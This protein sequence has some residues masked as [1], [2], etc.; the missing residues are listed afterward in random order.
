VQNIIIGVMFAFQV[1]LAAWMVN[2]YKSAK[3]DL[4]ATT[5]E[6]PMLKEVSAL[7][8]SVKELLS[9]IEEA[10]QETTARLEVRCA[11]ARFVLATLE[12]RL[13]KLEMEEAT[14]TAP[15]VQNYLPKPAA[16]EM[17]YQVVSNVPSPATFENNEHYRKH[18]V[19]YGLADSGLNPTEISRQTGIAEGEVQL[20]L[21]LRNHHAGA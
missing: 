4:N 20:L 7:Q 10:S 8:K 21:S 16:Q 18:Q 15:N 3:R 2:Y 14:A 5:A 11:E 17:A 13:A 6:A 19:I 12:D 1:V 9:A